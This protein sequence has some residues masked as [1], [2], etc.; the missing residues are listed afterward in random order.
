[1]I[2]NMPGV[3]N[4]ALFLMVRIVGLKGVEISGKRHLRIYDHY[5]LV[6]QA[7][8]HVRAL[9]LTV[10]SFN[11]GLFFKIAVVDHAGH[12]DRAAKLHLTPLATHLR[13]T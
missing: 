2:T 9:T 12:F 13:R 11:R 6:R 5:T 8:D 1:M 10:A 7:D 4:H 3:G